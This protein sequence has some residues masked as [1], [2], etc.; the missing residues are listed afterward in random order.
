MQF[1]L[2]DDEHMCSKHVEAWNKLI[3]KQKFCA[4]SWLITEINIL[5]PHLED[6]RF[7]R[8]YCHQLSSQA[9]P[10][11]V[12]KLHRS[13]QLYPPQKLNQPAACTNK[14]AGCLVMLIWQ[15]FRR[16]NCNPCMWST[17][18]IRS[19]SVRTKGPEKA[20]VVTDDPRLCY[21]SGTNWTKHFFVAH[22][23]RLETSRLHLHRLPLP[24]SI[25]NYFKLQDYSSTLIRNKAT[26]PVPEPT[27]PPT[28]SMSGALS[29]ELKQLGR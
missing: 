24:E 8:M 27:E 14:R 16:T 15:N 20:A 2:P 18:Q 4:L 13:R 7:L 26:R 23:M 17:W 22:Q 10:H 19:T 11:T 12:I 6:F 3:V 25:L 5:P 21:L 9:P 1:W 28:Q 29:T